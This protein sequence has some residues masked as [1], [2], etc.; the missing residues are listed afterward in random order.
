[1]YHNPD[2][3]MIPSAGLSGMARPMYRLRMHVRTPLI[4]SPAMTALV[5]RPV[6]L[7]LENTQPTAS[8]KLRGIGRLCAGAAAAGSRLFVSS[9]G[10]NA[11]WA[12]AYAARLLQC[13]AIVVV[14]ETTD[15]RMRGLIAG[16]GA[17]VIVHGAVWADAD[18][19]A[20]AIVSEKQGTYVPPFDHPEIWAGNSTMIDEIADEIPAPGCIVLSVGGGGLLAGVLDGLSRQGWRGCRVLAAETEGAASLT[21]AFQAGNP[22]TLPRVNTVARNLGAPRVAQGAFERAQ[23]WGVR[24]RVVSDGAAVRACRRFLDDQRMLVEPA[25]GAALATVYDGATDFA[26][27]ASV[28]VIVCGG[29]AITYDELQRYCTQLLDSSS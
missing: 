8:F 21:A 4:L 16:E 15:E 11:G 10:G 22:V 18:Q 26:D 23:A 7:K 13:R 29:A 12:A 14:P 27:A 2:G 25:C 5:K 24:A 6:Y 9:S 28:V 3:R 20:R 1:M 17:E 19:R